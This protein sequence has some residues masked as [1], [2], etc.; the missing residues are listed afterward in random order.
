MNETI[1]D[2][3]QDLNENISVHNLAIASCK[4]IRSNLKSDINLDSLGYHLS[5]SDYLEPFL[6]QTRNNTKQL[7]A[8]VK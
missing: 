5:V 6:C 7:S 8:Q 1:K 2:D 4:W 3:I